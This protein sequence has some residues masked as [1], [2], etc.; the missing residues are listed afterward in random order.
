M[1]FSVVQLLRRVFGSYID[2]SSDL[3]LEL[4][5]HIPLGRF[6]NLNDQYFI[7]L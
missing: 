2:L 4:I 3:A 1:G 5:N 7:Q 6:Q